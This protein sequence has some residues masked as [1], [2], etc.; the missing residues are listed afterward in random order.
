M[1]QLVINQTVEG[2]NPKLFGTL[3]K[4]IVALL[5]QDPVVVRQ[6]DQDQQVLLVALR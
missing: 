5:V 2:R 4:L 6:S 3:R 1:P